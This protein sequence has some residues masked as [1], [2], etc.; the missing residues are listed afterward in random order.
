[1]TFNFLLC[2]SEQQAAFATAVTSTE[3]GQMFHIFLYAI[4]ELFKFSS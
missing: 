1:M 4:E 3:K 2:I